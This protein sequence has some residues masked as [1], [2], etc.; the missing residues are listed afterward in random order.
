MSIV[1][2]LVGCMG[3]DVRGE[4]ELGRGTAIRVRLTAEGKH[5]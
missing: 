1:K 3:G 4:N 5:V 2:Q